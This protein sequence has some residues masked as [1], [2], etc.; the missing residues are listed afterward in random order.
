MSGGWTEA[1][2]PRLNPERVERIRSLLMDALAPD[3]IE[4]TDDSHKHAGHAG[5]RGGQGHFSVE[6]VSAAFAGKLP[7]ARHRLVYAALGDMLQTDIHA[8][9]IRARTP[10]E[11]D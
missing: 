6:I 9:A 10:E 1:D 5:A 3:A 2:I 11:V 4:V 7:L 8:L